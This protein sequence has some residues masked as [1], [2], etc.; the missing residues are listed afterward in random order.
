MWRARCEARRVQFV[1]ERRR[2]EKTTLY[3]VVRDN[4]ETLY[5]ATRESGAELP[6]FVRAE[7]EG[8]L[9]CGLLCRGFAHLRCEGCSERRLVAF[10]CKG[11]GFCPSCMGRR[12]AQTAANLMESVLPEAPLRQWV[13]TVPHA[14]RH[15]LAYDGKLLGKVTRAFL[16]A[17][18]AFYKRRCGASGC[19][20]VVQRTSSDLKLNPHVHAVFLDGG[21]VGESFVALGHLRG[22]DVAEVLAKAKRRIERLLAR[23]D[24]REGDDAQLAL[25]A[26]VSGR[27]PAGPALRRGGAFAEPALVSK[28]CVSDDGY[29]LHAATIAGAADARGREALLRYILRPPIAHE[30]IVAGPDNLVRIALKKPFSDG[31]VAVDMDPLSL[32]LRLCAAVPAPRFHTVRYAGVLASASKLRPKIVPQPEAAEDVDDE[33]PKKKGCRYWPWAEL[34]ARSFDLDVKKCTSCGARMKLV[35]L[36]QEKQSLARFMKMLGEPIDAPPRAPARDP[37]YYRSA[38]VRRLVAGNLAVA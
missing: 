26:S 15:R 16:G 23:A 13:L 34:M 3:A 33:E 18:L 11:R 22:T 9:D 17:V 6:A 24:V 14:I 25:L 5:A 12:M 4:V 10:S 28:L 30:R 38:V 21:Y 32:L 37:P 8:Y 27:A 31:T 29:N 19:I 35:A 20:A 7:L 36:V 2:P 1:Y